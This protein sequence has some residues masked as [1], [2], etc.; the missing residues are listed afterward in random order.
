MGGS[1][2]GPALA[3]ADR[4]PLRGVKTL[5]GTFASEKTFREH[6]TDT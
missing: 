1:P 6:G 4:H 3:R 5:A 2:V